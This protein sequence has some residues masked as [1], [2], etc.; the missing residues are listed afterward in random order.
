MAL[1]AILARPQMGYNATMRYV[2][3][4]AAVLTLSAGVARGDDQATARDHYIK[5]TRAYE[6]GLYAEA[7]AEYMAAYKTKDDPALLFN[8]GQAHR[9]AGHAA[10]ALRFYKTYLS[11]M[12]EAA[13]RADVESKIR[14]LKELVD[15]QKQAQA[16]PPAVPGASNPTSSGA[17]PP[18]SVPGGPTDVRRHRSQ[19]AS[20]VVQEALPEQRQPGRGRKL[21]GI[22][23][24]AGGLAL[25]GAGIAFGVLAKQAGDQLTQLDQSR[26]VFDPS[27]E[28]AG[29]RDQVLEGVFIGVGA[30]A[31][32]TGAI[33]YVVGARAG[34]DNAPQAIMLSPAVAVHSAGATLRMVFN[35]GSISIWFGGRPAAGGLLFAEL[36]RRQSQVRAFRPVPEGLPLRDGSDLLAQWSQ[37]RRVYVARRAR[38]GPGRPQQPA[39]GRDLPGRQRRRERAAR[40]A[41]ECVRHGGLHQELRL[42][43]PGRPEGKGAGDLR[44]Q[45]REPGAAWS[46]GDLRRRRARA[47]GLLPGS[48]GPVPAGD[49]SGWLRVL[50]DKRRGR[51]SRRVRCHRKPPGRFRERLSE[52]RRMRNRFLF[53]CDLDCRRH[54]PAQGRERR[55]LRAGL[56]PE[57]LP[58]WA[59]LRFKQPL[60]RNQA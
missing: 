51:S 17:V 37:P 39:G 46:P 56:V 2:V 55:Q 8:L 4:M 50:A 10:E 7:I 25:V 40:P 12:P 9:L 38:F 57:Q 41:R 34:R 60:F 35:A 31:V 1:A 18:G 29:R 36:S 22:V 24:A 5:G 14:E 59:L 26:G 30:A 33:L 44:V 48:G 52:R 20:G 42:L 15:K 11:K 47:H 6:L 13:N 54:L 43:H 16:E 32:V 21:A 28:S 49:R 27:K 53:G 19:A 58:G 23:T 45:H 3:A